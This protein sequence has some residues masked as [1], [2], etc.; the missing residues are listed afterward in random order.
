MG[1]KSKGVGLA[2][3]LACFYDEYALTGRS[4]LAL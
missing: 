2:D 4:Y 1:E 3:E